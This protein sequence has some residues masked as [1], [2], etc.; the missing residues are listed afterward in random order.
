MLEGLYSAAAGMAAQQQAIDGVANDLANV[1]TTGYKSVRVGFR[2]LI[3]NPQGPPAG[4]TV[5][6][7]AGAAASIIGRSQEQGALRTTDQPLDVAIS[8]PGFIQVRQPDGTPALTRDGSL[9]VDSLGRIGTA[10]GDLLDPPIQVPA[11][12]S[13]DRVGISRNGTV[14]VNGGRAIGRIQLVTVASSDGLQPLGSNRFAVTAASGAAGAAGAAT[15]LI[16]GHLEGSNV[17]M[18]S[19]MT[20]MMTAQRGYEM[21]SR[22]IQMQDD[23]MSIANGVKK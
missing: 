20:D 11:N 23:M 8:G 3:Y 19:A 1:N 5:S 22:V 10:D 12:T 14:T 9:R 18:S 17:D 6:A 13:I 15:T 21:T 7:G 4:P 16:Q 2:D